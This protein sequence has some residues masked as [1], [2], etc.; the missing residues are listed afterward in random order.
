MTTRISSPRTSSKNPSTTVADF[1]SLTDA[2]VALLIKPLITKPQNSILS[3]YYTNYQQAKNVLD[4][5]L[6]LPVIFRQANVAFSKRKQYCRLLLDDASDVESEIY[7]S[8][9]KS[10]QTDGLT[11]EYFE[12]PTFKA[13]SWF[14]K[15]LL[16]R[17]RDALKK[18]V[19]SFRHCSFDDVAT[20][21]D[22]NNSYNH[23]DTEIESLALQTWL[24]LLPQTIAN[25]ANLGLNPS[26]LLLWKIMNTPEEIT[27]QDFQCLN[28][29]NGVRSQ[30]TAYLLWKQ[31]WP[32]FNLRFRTQKTY[33]TI[34]KDLAI[35]V[36]H[37][38]NYLTFESMQTKMDAA[39]LGKIRENKIRRTLNRIDEQI[40]ENLMFVLLCTSP[41]DEY[42][43]NYTNMLKVALEGMKKL[44]HS[45][46]K[47]EKEFPNT[48]A[49]LENWVASNVQPNK[50][51]D[52]T[53]IETLLNL[54]YSNNEEQSLCQNLGVH[55]YE[56][57]QRHFACARQLTEKIARSHG[58]DFPLF[59]KVY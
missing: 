54:F 47:S 3:G 37:P 26:R 57:V 34:L 49:K 2:Q 7:R 5:K 43:M 32:T 36:L 42:L 13:K 6:I 14:K 59:I 17:G 25:D 46:R 45:D 52:F 33:N 16:N 48:I 21:V 44:C 35:F 51:I 39:E 1:N 22:E 41:K 8:L 15:V 12:S 28:G 27:F 55:K 53:K 23:H 11:C 40:W 10:L 38:V 20:T 30:N 29:K 50:T 9:L 56:K 31:E 19:P 18:G 24:K 4:N 58:P